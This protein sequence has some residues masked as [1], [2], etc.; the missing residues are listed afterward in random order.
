MI[1]G[2][3]SSIPQSENAVLANCSDASRA[4]LFEKGQLREFAPGETLFA[5]GE[6][7]GVTLLLLEGQV[8]LDK[9]TARGRRQVMCD[10]KPSHCGGLCLMFMPDP[11]LAGLRA[12]SE[13]K[14]LIIDSNAFRELAS[15]DAALCRAGWESAATCLKHMSGLIGHL[16]FRK[17]SERIALALLDNTTSD[18]DLVRWTQAELAAE[19]GTT[20]EVVARCLAGLQM[21]GA[22]RL[23]RGRVTVLNREKLAAEIK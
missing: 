4:A 12:I 18:G 3:L 22:V 23:G 20:R 16:S 13:G 17:V 10:A 6:A 21:A 14:A 2:H 15:N 1:T 9:T 5:E 8:Q 11:A 7:G 19:V